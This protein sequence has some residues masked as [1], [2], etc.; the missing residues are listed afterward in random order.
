MVGKPAGNCRGE[1]V[2]QS[3]KKYTQVMVLMQG[4][5]KLLKSLVEYVQITGK[6]TLRLIGT[7]HWGNAAEIMESHLKVNA[8]TAYCAF[9]RKYDCDHAIVTIPLGV[10]KSSPQLFTPQLDSG[11]VRF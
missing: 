2:F 3:T 7:Y 9:D 10:L 11:K 6:Q 8:F 1:K 5:E 4:W